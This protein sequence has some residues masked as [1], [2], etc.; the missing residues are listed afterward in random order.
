MACS[1]SGRSSRFAC[2]LAPTPPLPALTGAPP[3]CDAPLA[4]AVALATAAW[5]ITIARRRV[6]GSHAVIAAARPCLATRLAGALDGADVAAR[7]QAA[8]V[9]PV[10]DA[11][12]ASSA[13]VELDAAALAQYRKF[14]RG[15][16]LGWVRE[17]APLAG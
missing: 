17:W 12:P 3:P 8:A 9:E 14:S 2:I 11:V 4:A 15:A 6:T 1:G 5:G 7:R 10:Y 13:I 16:R